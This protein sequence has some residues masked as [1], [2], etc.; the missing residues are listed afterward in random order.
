MSGFFV[1]IAA[2]SYLINVRDFKPFDVG[3]FN[4]FIN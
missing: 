1:D 2:G 4:P 3:L